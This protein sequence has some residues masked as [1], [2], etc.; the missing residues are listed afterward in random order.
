MV[1]LNMRKTALY[2]ILALALISIK[3][4]SQNFYLKPLHSKM[5]TAAV[6]KEFGESFVST[7]VKSMVPKIIGFSFGT[8]FTLSFEDCNQNGRFDDIGIDRI[9][10]AKGRQDSVFHHASIS[11]SLITKPTTVKVKNRIYEIGPIDRKSNSITIS[12]CNNCGIT[13][14]TIKLVESLPDME[15]MTTAKV[16][17]PFSSLLDGK[18]M[19]YFEFWGTWCGPCLKVIPELKEIQKNYSDKVVLVGM[20][21]RDSPQDAIAFIEKN[22]ISWLNGFSTDEIKG[23]FMVLGFPYGILFDESGKLLDSNVSV[24]KLKSILSTHKR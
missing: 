24:S 12:E 15:F 7:E 21:F 23:E 2:L 1:E 3:C 16:F 13:K 18:R 14:P 6:I 9:S 10:V 19:I 20:N 17:V 8:E 4:H 11:S 22:E 5:F